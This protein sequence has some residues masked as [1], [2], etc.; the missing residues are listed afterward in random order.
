[1]LDNENELIL[2]WQ[3]NKNKASRDA[4]ILSH[5]H[6]VQSKAYRYPTS[7]VYE[8]EDLMQV[9][10]I[11]MCD[12]LDRF[13]VS[14]KCRFI[15]YAGH[16]V[17]F[18]MSKFVQL[19]LYSVSLYRKSAG[20]RKIMTT[21]KHLSPTTMSHVDCEE[22]SKKFSVPLHDVLSF[23]HLYVTHELLEDE[24]VS[25]LETGNIEQCA[26]KHDLLVKTLEACSK[27]ELYAL[28]FYFED[29]GYKHLIS[30]NSG[31]SST[32]LRNIAKEKIKS[33]TADF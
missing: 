19:N 31:R 9:G 10:T 11:G 5:K 14:H 23:C 29:V 1:M 17:K 12:A 25:S 15:T 30:S 32:H 20:M 22:Y 21:L 16:Y 4:V 27:Q 24:G 3:N 28:Q 2:D 33:F 7:A 13:T 8:L 26:I 6:F 18:E